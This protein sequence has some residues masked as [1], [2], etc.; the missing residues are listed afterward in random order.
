MSAQLFNGDC[1]DVMPRLPAG[2]VDLILCDLPYGTTQNKWDSVIPLDRLWAEY[3]RVLKPAGV[4]VLTAQCPFDKA[5]G[6]SCLEFMK[7]EWIWQKE[8]ATG[9][10]NAKKQPLKKPRKCAC[11]S[12]VRSRPTIR[13]CE[14]HAKARRADGIPHPRLTRKARAIRTYTNPGPRQLHG[15]GH[16]GRRRAQH[17]PAMTVTTRPLELLQPAARRLRPF[18]AARR[19]ENPRPRFVLAF[20]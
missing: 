15:L 5:L 4:A 6:A 7:Y 3:W 9:F 1:L 20:S 8:N 13:K 2:S 11:L 19:L 18:P 16:D 10:L 17:R 12:I 14:P